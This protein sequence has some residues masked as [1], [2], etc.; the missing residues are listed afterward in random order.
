MHILVHFGDA[1]LFGCLFLLGKF[2]VEGHQGWAGSLSRVSVS[3]A[4]IG[5]FFLYGGRIFEVVGLVGTFLETIAT[6]VLV[7]SIFTDLLVG[8]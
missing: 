5:K 7:S 6:I 4:Q 3:A 2:T 8:M 1:M